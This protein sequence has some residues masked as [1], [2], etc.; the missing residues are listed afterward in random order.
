MSFSLGLG[1]IAT[2]LGISGHDTS[3]SGVLYMLIAWPIAALIAAICGRY[4]GRFLS[5]LLM[6]GVL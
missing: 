3:F 1:L 2:L 5:S 4:I 6:L